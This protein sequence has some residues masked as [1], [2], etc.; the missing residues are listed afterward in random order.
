MPPG[1]SLNNDWVMFVAV[2][3]VVAQLSLHSSCAYRRWLMFSITIMRS[4]WLLWSSTRRRSMMMKDELS[5]SA[6]QKKKKSLFVL[7]GWARVFVFSVRHVWQDAVWSN[8]PVWLLSTVGLYA[9]VESDVSAVWQRSLRMYQWHG[10]TTRYQCLHIWQHVEK[11]LW[12]KSFH[13]II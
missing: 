3:I 7:L 1:V 2:P 5:G 13:P 4:V 11:S 8:G 6:L 9:A 12:L 10:T